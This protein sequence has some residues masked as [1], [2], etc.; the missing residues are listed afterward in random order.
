MD[1]ASLAARLPAAPLDP[2]EALDPF[3]A[4]VTELG[5]DLYPAQED[6][7]LE[8]LTGKHLIL[9]T[10]TGSGK[11][12]V[13]LGL[14]FKALGEQR[15][16]FY[17]APTK[18][19][20]NEKFFALCEALG[21]ERVGMLT[22]DASINRDA[23]VLCCTAE[24]LSNMTLREGPDLDAPYVVMDE[25]HYYGDRDR[26]TA[27]QVPLLVLRN[28]TFLL[29][30]ATLGDTRRIAAHLQEATGRE[31][32]HIESEL[33]PVPLDFEY[34]ETRTHETVEALLES[35]RAPVYLVHFTQREAAE[36]AQGLTSARITS[37]AERK[38]LGRALQRFQ[39]DTPY[40]R[41][42][43]RFARHGVGIHHAG[44]LPKYRLMME[45]LSQQGLLKVIC[46]TDTLG[47][48]VNI[49][50]RTVVFSRLAKFDGQKVAILKVR[51]FRQISGRAGRK[52]FDDQGWVV[53][54]AP[55]HVVESRKEA[56]RG[57]RRP[58][59][60]PKPGFVSW[61]RDTFRRL[62]ERPPETLEPRFEVTHGTLVNVMQRPGARD[63]DSGGYRELVE[64]ISRCH[65]GP[66][67][68]SHLRRQA[69]QRFRSLRQAGVIRRV[70]DAELGRHRVHVDPDLQWDFSLH[71]TLSLFLVEAVAVLDPEHPDYAL[72]VLTLVESILENP[73]HILRQ[74]A[75][76]LRR[77][78]LA[79]L[80]AARVPYEERIQKLDEVTHPKP[81][82]QFVYAAFDLFAESHPWIAEENIRP[83]AVAREMFERY[84]S[85]DDY[86]REY[87]LQRSEGLLLRYLAQVLNTLQQGVPASHK[88]DE[89]QDVISYLHTLLARVDSSLL[90]EWESRR[91][92]DLATP[93]SAPPPARDPGLELT[94]LRARVRSELH[95]L[96]RALARRDYAEAAR[97]VAQDPDDAWDPAR[98]E[99]ALAPFF[100]EYEHIVFEP[101]ARQA[102]HTKL[103]P[104]G[105]RRF[106]AV[107]V[108]VDPADDD[109]WCIEA[110]IELAEDRLPDGPLLRMRR[111][112]T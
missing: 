67:Q 37:P 14:H 75:E 52:G 112:G 46:G 89:V 15:R 17:T 69:A 24:V 25:F 82:A 50:I 18:A 31:V 76:K 80:K 94:T 84:A 101:R 66:G 73:V 102:Q 42:V 65:Q 8:L 77:D 35:G 74:Q 88:T 29:M 28:T 41:D 109:F 1:R 62:L 106:D 16:S 105:P 3:L 6:A 11:S 56:A 86:V 85:F 92:P 26:G 60:R 49:P 7:L 78:L 59:R 5:L 99:A 57:K 55:E 48:G 90:Q 2:E 81:D 98:F 63:T 4:W 58:P 70:Y 27:W 23:P 45:Q 110:W 21:P 93:A 53:C 54:Q 64:L 38:E 72:Q 10:P 32:S 79:R 19:L 44:L 87:V 108:L 91:R 47:V 68:K 20:V 104:S 51:E 83:K 39:F 9:Q 34:R 40:G 30:S 97:C 100:D 96:V 43:Q 95:G 107:Q 36:Q 61:N 12:L 111:I 33:R 71:H 22:G 13:A 103:D